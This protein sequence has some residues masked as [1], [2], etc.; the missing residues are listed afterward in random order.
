[1][2]VFQGGQPFTHQEVE[3]ELSDRGV[4]R[5]ET[6]FW[7]GARGMVFLGEMGTET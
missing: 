6:A 1:M 3:F 5:E 7:G 4:G 2:T